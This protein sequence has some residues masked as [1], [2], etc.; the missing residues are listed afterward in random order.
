RGSAGHRAGDT[1]RARAD[2][3]ADDSTDA[4]GFST[5][6]PG[7]RGAAGQAEGDRDRAAPR[8]RSAATPP[9][10]RGAPDDQA[11]GEHLPGTVEPAGAVEPSPRA[12]RASSVGG[13]PEPLRPAARHPAAGPG[14]APRPV[15]H[16]ASRADGRS[17]VA[18]SR[19]AA[20]S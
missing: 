18:R 8:G 13:A 2:E 1:A 17:A 16:P 3:S 14:Q 11:T 19:T 10:R 5:A 6:G 9:P 4:I 12:V 20:A 7:A 15:H